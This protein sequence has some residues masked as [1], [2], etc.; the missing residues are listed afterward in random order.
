MQVDGT[1]AEAEL[2]RQTA[3]GS[4]GSRRPRFESRHPDG[5]FECDVGDL[6]QARS[7]GSWR[8]MPVSIAL[9]LSTLAPTLHRDKAP[10]S[11]TPSQTDARRPGIAEPCADP[12]WRHECRGSV[13]T[14]RGCFQPEEV[15]TRDWSTATG[16][17]AERQVQRTAR[18]RCR[19][20]SQRCGCRKACRRVGLC[21]A[22][23]APCRSRSSAKRLRQRS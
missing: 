4:F 2:R 23:P 18:I 20:R 8:V 13:E 21:P 11:W 3:L 12:F 14:H 19:R 6:E 1:S 16:W 9:R 7:V 22:R 15:G 17:G 10:P 5:C